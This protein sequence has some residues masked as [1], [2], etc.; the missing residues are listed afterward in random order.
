MGP[1]IGLE[2]G[3]YRRVHKERM[4]FREPDD[5]VERGLRGDLNAPGD[6]MLNIR[7]SME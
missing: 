4:S 1:R 6:M 5:E 3:T 2:L 7:G